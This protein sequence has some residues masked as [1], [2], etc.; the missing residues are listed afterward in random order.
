MSLKMLNRLFWSVAIPAMVF[1]GCEPNELDIEKRIDLEANTIS[2]LGIDTSTPILNF[3]ATAPG[4]CSDGRNYVVNMTMKYGHVFETQADANARTRF[5]GLSGQGDIMSAQSGWIEVQ[6]SFESN[7]LR[8]F[9]PNGNGDPITLVVVHVDNDFI[10]GGKNIRN[11]EEFDQNF[12]DSF[13]KILD[14]NAAC[15]PFKHRTIVLSF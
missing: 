15:L 3:I 13:V 4:A 8:L 6:D 2:F 10:Y 14:S 7:G 5:D 9:G 12:N 11:I 1:M